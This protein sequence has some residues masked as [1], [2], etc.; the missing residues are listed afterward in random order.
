MRIMTILGSPRRHGN[1]ANVLGWI[2]EQFRADSHAVD[3]VNIVDQSVRGC[4]ECMACKKGRTEL[5]S[6]EDDANGLFRRMVAAEW[7]SLLPRSSAGAS[8]PNSKPFST[9]CSA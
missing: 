2:E 9:G 3:Q 8:R 7:C 1:T 5:C 4:G 6:I